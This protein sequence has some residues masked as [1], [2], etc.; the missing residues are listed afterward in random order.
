M[1]CGWDG[2]LVRGFVLGLPIGIDCDTNTGRV[3]MVPVR[4]TL[5]RQ[6]Q[7]GAFCLSA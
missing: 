3:L 4:W 7:M 5:A 6:A 2:D 1:G